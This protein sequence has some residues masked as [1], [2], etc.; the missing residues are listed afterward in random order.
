MQGHGDSEAPV[1]ASV[2][3]GVRTGD[4][5]AGR[6]GEAAA[7]EHRVVEV[8]NAL[9]VSGSLDLELAQLQVALGAHLGRARERFEVG[10]PWVVDHAFGLRDHL[11]LGSA[12]ENFAVV[13]DAGLH[14]SAELCLER[15]DVRAH[16]LPVEGRL[17][18]HVDGAASDVAMAVP[19]AFGHVAV[20]G[21][22]VDGVLVPG[23]LGGESRVD[24]DGQGAV[25]DHSLGEKS[26]SEHSFTFKI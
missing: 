4:V 22:G 23:V 19:L 7:A 3:A 11:C 6:V 24:L 8:E 15:R 5:G 18:R 10:A 20:G 1:A 12:V 2:A 17:D 26:L 14:L 13:G 25:G 16:L 21:E 9:S